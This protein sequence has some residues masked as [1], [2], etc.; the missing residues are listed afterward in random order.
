[1]FSVDGYYHLLATQQKSRD[2][3]K[4]RDY[5]VEVEEFNEPLDG[6]FSRCGPELYLCVVDLVESS[7]LE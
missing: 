1:M 5:R 7:T 3:Y 4:F 6:L 2:I